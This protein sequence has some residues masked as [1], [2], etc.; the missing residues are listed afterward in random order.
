MST[1]I[2]KKVDKVNFFY[3]QY[4]MKDGFWVSFHELSHMHAC[5]SKDI[6]GMAK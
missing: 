3:I 4:K 2:F 6:V 5:K 1:S